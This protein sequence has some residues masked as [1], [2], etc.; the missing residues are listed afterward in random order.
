MTLQ[1]QGKGQTPAPKLFHEDRRTQH[2]R[3]GWVSKP[4]TSQGDKKM[5][6]PK[7]HYVIC[8][9]CYLKGHIAPDCIFPFKEQ[10]QILKNY[11][12][13]TPMEKLSVPST[14]YTKVKS[15]LAQE[16]TGTPASRSVS[17]TPS[18]PEGNNTVAADAAHSSKN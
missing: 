3:P 15:L 7:R 9:I 4:S 10:S 14:S 13:L 8:H 17:D 2:G 11:E 1:G 12:A 5:P 6:Q 16:E 18:I